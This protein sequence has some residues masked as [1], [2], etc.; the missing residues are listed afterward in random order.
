VSEV[1]EIDFRRVLEDKHVELLAAMADRNDIVIETTADEI[2]RLQ[3]RSSRE[4]ALRNL[5]QTTR[6]LKQVRAAL[7]RIEDE[8]YGVCLRCEEPIPLKRLK[9]LPWAAYCVGCQEIVDKS[10]RFG[11]ND[12]H[13]IEF[14]A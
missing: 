2:E 12:G 10:H 11:S 4:V 7:D 14:A 5:D 3:Q 13:E 9:A 1:N 8:I 6:L